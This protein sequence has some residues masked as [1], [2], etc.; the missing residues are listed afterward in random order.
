MN[1]KKAE[2]KMTAMQKNLMKGGLYKA[3][4]EDWRD[5]FR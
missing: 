5:R 2:E 3:V 1:I 4:S